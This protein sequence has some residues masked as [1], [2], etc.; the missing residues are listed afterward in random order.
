MGLVKGMSGVSWE[1]G[2]S[3]VS[4]VNGGAGKGRRTENGKNII[5]I[6]TKGVIIINYKF[7]V[8]KLNLM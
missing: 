2:C 4:F 7:N 1:L 3:G 5:D 8:I 6:K